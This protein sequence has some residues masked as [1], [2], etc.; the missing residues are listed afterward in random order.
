[1]TY[2][3]NPDAETAYRA[4]AADG[5]R[6]TRACLIGDVSACMAALGFGLRDAE[7][8]LP[9]W[10]SDEGRQAMVER[11]AK[12][13]RVD[14]DGV[15]YRRCVEGNDVRAC[16]PI[17]AEL[18]WVTSPPVSDRLRAHLLWF[19]ARE[20]GEGAWERA[21]DAGGTSVP[22]VLA[23]IADRPIEQLV[24]DWRAYVVTQRPDVHAGLGGRGARAL[25][26]SLI[27]AAL[28]MRST[29]WRLA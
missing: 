20:G 15:P 27:F 22:E 28:A 21:I 9:A 23:Q 8:R 13:G 29:R 25:L 26:W 7:D 2:Q 11:A 14:R 3:A 17:L 6:A 18:D 1:M 12:D 24:Q 4:L 10:F 19:A 5:S 16:D